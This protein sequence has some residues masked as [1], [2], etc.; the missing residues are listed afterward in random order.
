MSLTSLLNKRQATILVISLSPKL[1]MTHSQPAIMFCFKVLDHYYQTNILCPSYV[2]FSN[3]AS[4]NGNLY[5][6]ILFPS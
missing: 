4:T 1:N 2:P 6:F 3:A 5:G